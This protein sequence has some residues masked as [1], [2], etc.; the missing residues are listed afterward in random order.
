VPK[1]SAFPKWSDRGEKEKSLFRIF[2]RTDLKYVL[3]NETYYLN[4]VSTGYIARVLMNDIT[5][6]VGKC[7]DLFQLMVPS[8]IYGENEKKKDRIK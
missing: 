4:L 2:L 5:K 1:D 8:N 7:H 6:V 3:C